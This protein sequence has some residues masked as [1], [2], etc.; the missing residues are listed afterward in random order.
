[1]AVIFPF[2]KNIYEKAQVPVS[3]VGH[4]L[5]E[6]ITSNDDIVSQRKALNLPLDAKY[7]CAS[8]R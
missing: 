7:Y 6:K 5:V 8:A 4:P 3:F 2:E 1:M